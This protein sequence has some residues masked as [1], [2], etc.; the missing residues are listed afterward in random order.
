MTDKKKPLQISVPGYRVIGELGRGGMGAVLLAQHERTG[1][2]YAVKVLLGACATSSAMRDR[3]RL[4]AQAVQHCNHPNIVRVHELSFAADGSPFFVMERLRGRSLHAEVQERGALPVQEA[5]AFAVQ[6]FDGLAAAHGAGVLHRDLKLANVFVCDGPSP[7]LLKIVDFGVAR[8]FEPAPGAPAPLALPTQEGVLIGTPRYCSPEALY[9]NP[10]LFGPRSDLY[11]AGLVVHAL[12][13]GTPP[14]PDAGSDAE[15][16]HAQAFER[17]P[18]LAD[19]DR[20][21]AF[22]DPIIQQLCQKNPADR[23]GSAAEVAALFRS[24]LRERYAAEVVLTTTDPLP[25]RVEATPSPPAPPPRALPPVDPL[26][27]TVS[28]TPSP[29]RAPAPLRAVSPATVPRPKGAARRD[30]PMVWAAMAGVFCAV[31]IV[32]MVLALGWR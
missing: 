8:I 26:E 32:L 2:A 29:F 30:T 23:F 12:F 13:S 22:L 14:W 28:A 20:T 11:S 9:G 15:L 1:H 3:M 31:F 4:E 17:M 5:L 24:A 7:R 19:R 21:L 25:L 16:F 10:A 27:A 18:L 6:L